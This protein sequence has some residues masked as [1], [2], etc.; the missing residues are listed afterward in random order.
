MI[1]PEIA[2]LKSLIKN[3]HSS[4]ENQKYGIIGLSLSH[5]LDN[6]SELLRESFPGLS[7]KR[8]I[9]IENASVKDGQDYENIKA[10]I[11]GQIHNLNLTKEKEKELAYLISYFTLI[12]L[13]LPNGISIDLSD[14]C[15]LHCRI[16]SQWK[17]RNSNKKLEFNDI[18]KV[19]D[20]LAVFSPHTIVEFSGQ[21][22]LL[23]K[24][25]LFEA[26]QYGTKK[27]I[28]MSLNTN[29]TLLKKGDLD[30]LVKLSLNHITISI[31]GLK[32]THNNIRGSDKAFD[33]STNAMKQLVKIKK[34]MGLS[35]PTASVTFVITNVN[36]RELPRFHDFLR[37]VGVETLNL[38]PF[39]LDNSY[40]FN[41]GATYEN[42]EFWIKETDI[43][44]LSKILE[45]IIARKNRKIFPII[46]NTEKQL[47][48][49]PEYF[50]NR[51]KYHKRI[52][53]AGLNYFHITNFGE[54]TVCGRG[55]K[56][57]IREHSLNYIWNSCNF[58]KTRMAVQEC[59]TPCLSN[60]FELM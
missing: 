4:G 32:E 46:T 29:G 44:E 37:E 23:K 55:P 35:K 21:E 45:E 13:L 53:M 39:T 6:Q 57:N 17:D 56:L 1:F 22:P 5:F 19:I 50:K 14:R 43:P 30:K 28:P 49:I 54:V 36:Y 41:K 42:N 16:C 15:N 7:N 47:S 18:K 27:G 38:N 40:F 59:A 3:L 33:S 51:E 12:P 10:R 58:L 60:C 52:C 8:V 20:D 9:S 25:L 26:L 2:R 34:E 11:T 48:M 24:E 31:D